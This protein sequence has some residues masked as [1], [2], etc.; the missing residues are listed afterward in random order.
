MSVYQPKNSRIWHYD[1]VI[2]R[3]RYCGSTGVLNRRAAEE[4]ERK[5]RREAAL[6]EL[7]E[8]ARLTLDAACGRYWD[9]VGKRRGDA[10]DVERRLDVV[11]QL[12]GKATPLGDITQD[13]VA[14]A[15]E[16]RRGMTFKKGKDRKDAQGRTVKAKEYALSDS[17][18]N[19]DVIETLRPVLN[20]ARTHWTAKGKHG[21]PDIDWRELHLKEP[22]ALSR[23][24]SPAQRAAWLAA[25]ADDLD[26]ALDMILTYGLR[27][28]EIFFAPDQLNLD[29]DEP[30]LTL[31]KGRKKDVILYLPLRQDHARRLAARHSRGV[32][33]GLPHLWYYQ[34]GKKLKAF[35]PSQVEYRISKAADTA[36]IGGGRRIHGGRHHAGSTILKKTKN[37]KMV[38]GL[39]GH[40]TIA[41]SQRY[42]HVL[43]EDLRAVLDDEVPR[44]SPEVA[45]GGDKAADAK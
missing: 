30:T 24:Y 36:G 42:A 12:F 23:I 18:V 35:T 16:K 40:A 6:G 1:F 14:A 25:C 9:E 15:I 32:E 33:A 45:A 19:R 2:Q 20:R 41:S 31:Q 44:N 17:T 37:L 39:L 26:L 29:P 8:V 10:Q 34:A 7:G 11:L 27:F 38:Q 13:K 28:G 3:Q 21:L 5:K 4:V 43:M 22:R